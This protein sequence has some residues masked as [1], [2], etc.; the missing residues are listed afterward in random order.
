MKCFHKAAVLSDD[1][2][3]V[4]LAENFTEPTNHKRVETGRH[5]WQS[6]SP[7][8]LYAVAGEPDQVGLN[9]VQSGFKYLQERRLQP[10]WTVGPS[11]LPP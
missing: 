9:C 8:S 5:L 1:E 3:L 11:A 10:L 4:Q 2:F 6:F 7:T